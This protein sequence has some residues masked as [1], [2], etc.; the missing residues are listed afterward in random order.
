MQQS[1][2]TSTCRERSR[3]APGSEGAM[4][5]EG[6]AVRSIY[7]GRIGSKVTEK[8]LERFGCDGSFLLRDSE[9]VP[10][11]YCLCVRKAPFVHTYRLERDGGGGGG[12]YLQDLRGRLLKFGTVES[13]I[14][15]YRSHPTSHQGVA[16]L[17]LPLDRATVPS[18]WIQGL[19]YMEMN[20]GQSGQ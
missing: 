6:A 11:A 15:H 7:Y 12:W 3:W 1:A 5:T 4:E 17:T 9:T 10:G 16:P 8:L 18:N 2:F 13:L 20:G 19:V 14:D